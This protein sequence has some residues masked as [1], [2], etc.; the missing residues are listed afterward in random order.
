THLGK[1]QVNNVTNKTA[2]TFYGLDLKQGKNIIKAVVLDS[3]EKP[4]SEEYTKEVFVKGKPAKI[5]VDRARIPADGKTPGLVTVNVSDKDGNP[6]VDGTVVTVVIN[7][8]EIKSLDANLTVAG[9]QVLTKDGKATFLVMPPNNVDTGKVEVV[10]GD[11]LKATGEID[12]TTPLRSPIFMALGKLKSNYSFVKGQTIIND[13]K[14]LAGFNYGLGL[15]LFTQ[16]TIFNDFLLT[17]ALNTDR[18]LNALDDDQNIL[19]RDRAE[20]KTYPIYGDSSQLNQIAVSNS[21]VYV[22]LEKDKSSVLWGDFTTSPK[23]VDFTTPTM[24]NYNRVLTGAKVDLDIPGITNLQVFGAM[25]NQAFDRD[26]IKGAGVSG[27]YYTSKYPLVNGSERITIE[28][29]DRTFNNKIISTKT[30]NRLSDYNIDY[31]N[32]SIIFSQPVATFD[33]NLNPN[34]IIINYEY[35]PNSNV[36][37]DN[38][39][40]STNNSSISNGIVGA[41]LHQPLP[42]LGAFVGGSYIREVSNNPYQLFGGNFGSKLNKNLD[43]I[44]EYANSNFENK[45]GNSYRAALTS[46]PSDNLS[47]TGEYVYVDPNFLNRAGGSYSVGTERYLARGTYRPFTSTNLSVEYNR[48]NSFLSKQLIQTV[49]GNITQDIFSNAIT[50]GFEGRNFPD[51]KSVDKTLTAGLLNIGYKSPTFYNIS[52]NAS[53]SQ[54]VLGTVDQLKPTLT[55]F[56]LDYALT[57]NIK[58]YA[59]QDFLEKEKLTTAT[60][61]GVDTGFTRESNFLNA[62]NVGAKYQIDGAIGGRDAQ[63]RIGLN[64]KI[65]VL[66]EL[67]LGLAYERVS[68]TSPVLNLSDDHNAWSVS[69][70][71]TP[72]YLGVRASGKYDVRDGVRA[73]NL[74]SFNVAG[75]LGDDFSL[76]GRFNLSSSVELT[77]RSTTDG[78]FGLAYRPLSNDYFNALLKYQVRN[79]IAGIGQISDVTNHIVSFEGFIQPTYAWEIYTKLAL[80][81]S[82]DKTGDF[83]PVGGNIALGLARVT[84][85]FLYNFDIA[86]EYRNL[87]QIESATSFNDVTAELGYYPVKDLRVGVGY[88]LFGYTDRDLI[89]SNYTSQG[90]YVNLN[91]K[92]NNLGSWWGQQG[93]LSQKDINAE[94][95]SAQK[96]KENIVANK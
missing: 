68:G 59:K 5:I 20:D 52:L 96:D 53:R 83:A 51:P 75:A 41:S 91:F 25:T 12:Y 74:Y 57:N 73:S 1:T 56:G 15:N 34:F 63:T 44:A 93:I 66:P 76:F 88:N 70:D 14:G 60:A 2:Y 40:K 26:E 21:N 81:N 77:R 84:Y 62:V 42:F 18:K 61:I 33:E 48:N 78:L 86:A 80:K 11:D 82:S 23:N 19:L 72:S 54:N 28:T 90:P 89:A 6:V 95:M 87:T 55:S 39:A 22:K 8:G 10:V 27:P 37:K 35:Y 46:A 24:T 49:T 64:N 29:R 4:T 31:N 13:V 67:G 58:L 32:G 69:A 92:L 3:M 17:A 30:L 9:F 45:V 7:I 47:L 65:N 79:S 50:L 71:Y 16:G 43:F 38:G 85:K 94:K 36:E